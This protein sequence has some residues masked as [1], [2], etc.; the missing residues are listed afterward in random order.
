MNIRVIA[1]SRQ[2]GTQ[3]EEIAIEVSRRLGFR[4]VD[5]Q[6]VQAA[7]QEANVSPETVGEAE[8]TPSLLT[9]ILEAL[10]RSPSIP[11]GGWT[12]PGTLT[13]SPLVTSTDY[14][15]F[16][17]QVIRDIAEEGE[18][19]ILGHGATVVLNQRPD[20]LRA[21]VTG[22]AGVRTK[23]VMESMGV[24]EKEAKRIVERTDNERV[25]YFERFYQAEW[26]ATYSY[27]LCVNSD[28]LTTEQAADLIVKA[29]HV[30]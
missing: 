24:D 25:H 2:I 19:V 21:M 30:S 10:A 22:T 7:A 3:G 13:T 29:A 23:R 17:E 14:R 26:L 12:D 1:L 16:I 11:S 20:T 8:H 27:D 18:S 5:Y 4:Y 15:R 28:R 9:R 6:V